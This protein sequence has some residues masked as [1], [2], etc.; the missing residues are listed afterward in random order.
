MSGLRRG[1]VDERVADGGVRCRAREVRSD[2]RAVRRP[3]PPE[4]ADGKVWWARAGESACPVMVAAPAVVA[5]AAEPEINA[6]PAAAV[7]VPA[8]LPG[9]SGGGRRESSHTSS[10]HRSGGQ[11]GQAQALQRGAQAPRGEAGRCATRCLLQTPLRPHSRPAGYRRSGRHQGPP[12]PPP[13][14][15]TE[16]APSAGRADGQGPVGISRCTRRGQRSRQ[17]MGWPAM[18]NR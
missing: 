6:A 8:V 18:H 2:S 4:R 12:L 16:G 7:A 15:S 13:R 14:Q 11:N 3:P 10:R 17:Q 5:Q 9:G 1:G